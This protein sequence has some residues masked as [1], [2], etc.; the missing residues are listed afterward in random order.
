MRRVIAQP[1]KM[2]IITKSPLLTLDQNTHTHTHT[3]AQTHTHTA[4][5]AGGGG[6]VVQED[7]DVTTRTFILMNA[8]R[9]Q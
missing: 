7:L 2:N 5:H 3:L 1:I 9:N 8:G 4:S 6:G